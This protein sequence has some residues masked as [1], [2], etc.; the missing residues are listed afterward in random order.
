M[1]DDNEEKLNTKKMRK[2]A[3]K[4]KNVLDRL[5]AQQER[6][7]VEDLI[8]GSNRNVKILARRS[9]L[10]MVQLMYDRG[11]LNVQLAWEALDAELSSGKP[12]TYVDDSELLALHPNDVGKIYTPKEIK[13]GNENSE[14]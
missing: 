13:H 12:E 3:S 5:T 14:G 4:I 2:E 8:P 11:V 6:A 7:S 9:R 1:T 10:T